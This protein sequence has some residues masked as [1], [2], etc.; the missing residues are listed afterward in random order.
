MEK[1]T[2]QSQ[3]VVPAVINVQKIIDF[4]EGSYPAH[5][6]ELQ[7]NVHRSVI[8]S[9]RKNPQTLYRKSFETVWKIHQFI[10]E[11]DNNKALKNMAFRKIKS[12]LNSDSKKLQ[13]DE[14]ILNKYEYVME[15]ADKPYAYKN[16]YMIYEHIRINVLTGDTTF[17]YE[18]R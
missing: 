4:L 16:V 10:E 14:S 3:E 9:L 15:Y 6:I 12:D 1:K 8:L 7:V 11:V 5:Q 13:I 2:D 18:T 17:I